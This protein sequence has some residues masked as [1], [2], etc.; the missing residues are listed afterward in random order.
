M[1]ERFLFKSLVFYIA[2]NVLPLNDIGENNQ[3]A[4]NF[5]LI[6][7]R[8]QFDVSIVFF[9]YSPGISIQGLINI[10]RYI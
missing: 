3:K 10:I 8:N 7:G 5:T 2:K 6:L 4:I 9:L 1:K